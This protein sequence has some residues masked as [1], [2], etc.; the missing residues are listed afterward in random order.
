MPRHSNTPIIRDTDRQRRLATWIYVAPPANS[1]D[2]Y[3]RVTSPERLDRLADQ[4]YGNQFD[5]P[6]I[7]TANGIGKGT[8]WVKPNTV[9]RIPNTNN[10]N[11]LVT[12]INESR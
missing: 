6:I 9:L 10:N 12:N 3:I 8:V 7:A 2:T 5:W 1:T 4:F 11:D